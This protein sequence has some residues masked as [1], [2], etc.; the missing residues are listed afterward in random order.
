VW[1]TFQ[2][3]VFNHNFSFLTL[4]LAI[5]IITENFPNLEKERVIHVQEAFRTPNRQNKERKH[6]P[7]KTLNMQNKARILKS[8]REK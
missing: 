4:F 8:V 7:V 1:P 5:S 3:S 2:Y 6:P